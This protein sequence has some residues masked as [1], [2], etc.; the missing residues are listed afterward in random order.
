MANDDLSTRAP[1]SHE[2]ADQ[3]KEL[4]ALIAEQH[5]RIAELEANRTSKVIRTHEPTEQPSRR[6]LLRRAGQVG[7]ATAG[8]VGGMALLSP[9]VAATQGAAVIAG[10]ANTETATTVMEGAGTTTVSPIFSV[11]SSGSTATFATALHAIAAFNTDTAFEANGDA[12]TATASARAIYAHTTDGL[13]VQATAANGFAVTGAASAPGGIG[14][15][16]WAGGR[17]PL[18]VTPAG[19]AGAPTTNAHSL[20]DIWTDVKGM[21]WICV[22]SGTPGV[23]AP[24]QTGGANIS[25]FVKVSNTQFLLT[26]SDG[27]TWQNLD[28]T[29]AL[30]LVIT[31]LFSA[32]AVISIS[33][34]L[35]TASAGLNQDIGVYIE[36]GTYGA[37]GAGK[38]IA[39]KESGGSAGTFSPNAAFVETTQPMVAGTAYTIIPRWKTNKPAGG[40]IIAA[41][42]GPLPN[43]SG[44]GGVPG[45]VSPTRLAVH[46]IPDV[47]NPVVLAGPVVPQRNDPSRVPAAPKLAS[48]K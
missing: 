48:R 4:K 23:F 19:A 5:R 46:L 29:G 7:V 28:G 41:G 6:D 31:P 16:A 10:V 13:A 22:T 17:A 24:L 44:G 36:G 34:D 42:A 26:N 30:K 1:E 43:P 39:W 45:Q 11:T 21:L 35:W 14:V 40:G 15:V 9:G 32:Q 8:A 27:A 33:V 25:H 37:A 47:P 18:S 2:I 38:I 20:G 12:M 3:V